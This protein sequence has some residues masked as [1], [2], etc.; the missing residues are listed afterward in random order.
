M[1]SAPEDP[2][3]TAAGVGPAGGDAAVPG[4]AIA[5]PDPAEPTLTRLT[6]PGCCTQPSWSA[7][8]RR[9]QYIDQPAPD[10]PVG[11]WTVDADAP[12]AAPVLVTD[13]IGYYS[14]DLRY[15]ID[16]AGDT[17]AL[18]R[19]ADG[20]R[21]TVPADGRPI[22]IAP[23]G[24]RIA[25][26][27][28]PPNADFERRTTRVWVA[29]IDGSGAR[30][31]GALPRGSLVAWIDAGT[32]LLRGRDALEAVDDVLWALDVDDGARREIARAPNLRGELPSPGGGWVA[33]Y[34]ARH[35]DPTDTGMWIAST[36]G[37]APRRIDKDL[38]GAYRWRD[39][40][41]LL[42]VPQNGDGVSHAIVEVD[43]ATLATRRLTDPATTP[44]KIAN[45]DWTVAPDGRRIAFVESRDKSI[46]VLGLP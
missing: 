13:E 4:A 2:T 21:W 22:T 26:Q 34:V 40:G 14:A 39:D 15:R 1:G 37:G 8:G 36:A 29:G 10:Q 25:W 44:F 5:P 23:D 17:T 18:V 3:G 28:S 42:V 30:E 43:V 41:R 32:L 35:E 16:I 46:W 24:A 19:L 7:D 9:V 33:Y 11:V 12:G 27:V 31:V 6:A 20:E 38:F 45:G